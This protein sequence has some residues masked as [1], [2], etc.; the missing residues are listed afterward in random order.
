MNKKE[1]YASVLT[2][3]LHYTILNIVVIYTFIVN[4]VGGVENI[5]SV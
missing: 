1:S 4:W 2:T 3:P 5:T